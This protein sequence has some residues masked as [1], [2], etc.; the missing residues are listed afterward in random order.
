MRQVWRVGYAGR[1]AG[2]L[3]TVVF[4]GLMVAFAAIGVQMA[5]SGDAFIGVL[6][7]IGVCPLIGAAGVRCWLLGVRPNIT[8]TEDSVVVRNPYKTY[9]VS[10]A[11]ISMV[12]GGYHGLCFTLTDGRQIVAWAVQKSNI[13]R[14]LGR[15]TRAD[16]VTERLLMAATAARHKSD[17]TE[18]P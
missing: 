16:G 8:L 13:A 7:L 2:V 17:M 12:S 1:I 10:L 3:G 11:E 5:V 9:R 6:S 14:W 15:R 18:T 4:A